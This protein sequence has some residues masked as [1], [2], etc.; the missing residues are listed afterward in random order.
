MF[1]SNFFNESPIVAVKWLSWQDL[2]FA[3]ITAEGDFGVYAC[4]VNR[5]DPLAQDTIAVSK[6]LEINTLPPLS[7]GFAFADINQLGS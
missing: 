4:V 6:L 1:K 7:E 2:K 3:Y 5:E